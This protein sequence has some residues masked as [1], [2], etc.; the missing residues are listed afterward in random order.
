[1]VAH[2]GLIC[3]ISD[4]DGEDD[5]TARLVTRLC[6]HNDVLAIFVHDP[7]EQELPDIGQATFSS[8][9][10]QI[11]V[12][13]SASSLRRSFAGERAAWRARLAQLSRSRAIPVLPI[14]TAR[15]VADQLRELIGKRRAQQVAGASGRSAP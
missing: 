11:E 7:L 9:R 14:S 10:A 2:D 5:E 8:G 13:A 15:G 1:M 3:L 12:D 4:V 6:A